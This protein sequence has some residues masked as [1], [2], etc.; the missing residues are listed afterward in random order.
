MVR[1]NRKYLTELKS[2]YINS[3]RNVS[4]TKVA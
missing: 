3:L 1:K 2:L 4:L